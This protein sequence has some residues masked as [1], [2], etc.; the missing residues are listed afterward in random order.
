[1]PACA[2]S[3][4]AVG[5]LQSWSQPRQDGEHYTC[6]TSK[7]SVA[8]PAASSVHWIAVAASCY[9]QETLKTRYL[10]LDPMAP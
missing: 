8:V 1:M 7:V 2:G 9:S 6:V 3:A 5:S 10:Q 4:W